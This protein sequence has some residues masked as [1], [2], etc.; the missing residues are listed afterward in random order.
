MKQRKPDALDLFD[1]LNAALD[2]FGLGRA[3]DRGALEVPTGSIQS[4]IGAFAGIMRTLPLE[5]RVPL[6]HMALVRMES[7][8]FPA[9]VLGM[10]QDE[11]GVSPAQVLAHVLDQKTHPVRAIG[12]LSRL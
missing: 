11:S 1:E 7:L 4:M 3:C 6:L 8:A 2:Q 9:S 10:V 5:K 12:S